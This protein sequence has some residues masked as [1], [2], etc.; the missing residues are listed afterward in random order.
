MSVGT[1]PAISV[2]TQL[3][4][5]SPVEK[6]CTQFGPSSVPVQ[7]TI[8]PAGLNCW[9]EHIH[10]DRDRKL[11]AV[12]RGGHAAAGRTCPPYHGHV[13]LVAGTVDVELLVVDE[14][15]DV[16]S[17]GATLRRGSA[18]RLVVTRPSVSCAVACAAATTLPFSP[19]M[20]LQGSWI[21]SGFRRSRASNRL[22]RERTTQTARFPGRP[23]AMIRKWW[24][25]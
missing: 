15:V 2:S 5:H 7:E 10:G 18:R 25:D 22:P 9:R 12:L 17:A 13:V 3:M 1:T 16:D 19:T 4:L 11:T 23:L 21:P 8:I 14:L 20:S 6:S 24:Q